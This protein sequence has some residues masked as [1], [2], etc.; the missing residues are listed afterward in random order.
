MKQKLLAIAFIIIL[1]MLSFL[2][3]KHYRK[4]NH[5][6]NA[7]EIKIEKHTNGIIGNN[8]LNNTE[9][10]KEISINKDR[11]SEENILEI[12]NFVSKMKEEYTKISFDIDFKSK[13]LEIYN[14]N[15]DTALI[16]KKIII[17]HDFAINLSNKDQNYARIFAT[18]GLKEIAISG[19]QE[20]LISTVQDFSKLLQMKN[21]SSKGELA[22]LDDLLRAYISINNIAKFTENLENHLI[23]VGFNKSIKNKDVF[24]I[25]DQAFYF[26]LSN[27]IGREKAKLL[28]NKYFGS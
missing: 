16:L 25:Y 11:Y 14:K 22:D 10:S 12:K 7:I 9:K 3:Y 23:T 27:K 21:S 17:D 20:P 24:D 2:S 18:Q 4:L 1:I 26:S 5:Y 6:S 15:K 19:N 13:I 8:K 28:L